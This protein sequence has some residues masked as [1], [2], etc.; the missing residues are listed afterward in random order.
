MSVWSSDCTDYFF[1]ENFVSNRHKNEKRSHDI[2]DIHI[3]ITTKA[4][5]VAN[6]YDIINRI[7]EVFNGC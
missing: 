1:E 7:M 6:I 2:T 5:T 3:I 4:F